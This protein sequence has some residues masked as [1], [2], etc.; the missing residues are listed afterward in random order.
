M[1]TMTNLP[2][3]L[4][5]L[6]IAYCDYPD[7]TLLEISAHLDMTYSSVKTYNAYLYNHFGVHSQIELFDTLGWIK[8]SSVPN[9][10]PS[11]QRVLTTLASKPY[12]TNSELA[13]ALGLSSYTVTIYLQRIFSEFQVF[14]RFELFVAIGWYRPTYNTINNMV[15]S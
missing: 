13:D 8:P 4:H 1:T 6:L 7:A 9:L 5:K 2:N 10:I 14:T 15:Q 11:L 3:Y 12:M